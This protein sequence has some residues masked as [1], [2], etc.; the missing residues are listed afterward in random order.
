[1]FHVFHYIL[2]F[3]RAE[4]NFIHLAKDYNFTLSTIDRFNEDK[5][6]T[7]VFLD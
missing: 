6:M 4:D 3:W 2:L 1:M 7:A 5:D